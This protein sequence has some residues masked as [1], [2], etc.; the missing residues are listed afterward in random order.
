LLHAPPNCLDILQSVAREIVSGELQLSERDQSS[1]FSKRASRLGHYFEALVQTLFSLSPEIEEWHP[2]LQVFEGKSTTGEFDLLYKRQGHWWHLELAIKY[3]IGFDDLTDADNW[4]GPALRDNLGRKLRRLK[5]HQLVLPQTS[6]GQ[7]ALSHLGIADIT[8]EALVFGQLFH[9]LANWEQAL[10]VKPHEIVANHP[11]GWWS[12][13]QN[14]PAFDDRI[15]IEL[16]KSDWLSGATGK[17]VT[18][19]GAPDFSAIERPKMYAVCRDADGEIVETSRGFVV[20][21]TWGPVSDGA[22]VT[23]HRS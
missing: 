2:N 10:F 15:W 4:H 19:E 18:F 9:P 7:L 23:L 12:F 3:Y 22:G 13:A 16:P 20:P 11:I 5:H 8:S 17:R 1:L 14:T 6:A 21:N